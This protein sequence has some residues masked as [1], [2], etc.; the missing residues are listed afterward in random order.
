MTVFFLLYTVAGLFCHAATIDSTERFTWSESGG[1]VNLHASAGGKI[2][3]YSTH[4]TGYAWSES[5]GWIKLGVDAGGPYSNTTNE[6][7]GVNKEANGNLSG[8]AWSESSGWINFTPA[9]GG[10]NIDPATKLLTG[11]AWS[12]SLGWIR[13]D[14]PTLFTASGLNDPPISDV[15]PLISGTSLV[16]H[17]LSG[18][19]GSWSDRD[20]DTLNFSYQWYRADDG[21]GTNE[22]P[23]T[24]AVAISY[25]ITSSDAHKFLKLGVT[26]DD[27]RGSDDQQAF[28]SWMVVNNSAPTNSTPPAI[29]NTL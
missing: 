15:P 27:R 23:V 28:S 25:T 24:D 1:W 6:N 29:N 12:E 22:I 9:N 19:T 20:G 8:F 13:F 16:S 7:W 11:F 3:I 18:T 21:N 2:I 17:Q 10:V 14:H 26:A 4:L 5:C